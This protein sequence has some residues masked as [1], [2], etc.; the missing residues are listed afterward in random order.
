MKYL[1]FMQ[2]MAFALLLGGAA[3][4][5]WADEFADGFMAAAN[6]DYKAALSVWKPLAKN[7][8]PDAQFNLAL[9]L[10]SG[11]SGVMDEKE[12]VR[13]YHKAAENGHYNAQQYLAAAYGE[14][15]FG[16]KKDPKQAAYWLNKLS[17][18]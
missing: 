11:A 1:K 3:P 13:L 2:N 18:R 15:W 9:I 5:L 4:L 16:L 10:H 17:A 8:H 14:G 6:G 7:G 12:A